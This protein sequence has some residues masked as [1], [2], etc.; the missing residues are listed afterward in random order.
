[1]KNHHL[2]KRL[3]IVKNVSD[4]LQQF[5]NVK[6]VAVTGSCA[7]GCPTEKSDIDLQ[8]AFSEMPYNTEIEK[9]RNRLLDKYGQCKQHKWIGSEM[10]FGLTIEDINISV[11]YGKVDDFKSVAFC[12]QNIG[13]D[14]ESSLSV[15]YDMLPFYDSMNICGYIRDN[16]EYT[17]EKQTEILSNKINELKD[18]FE[19]D[20]LKIL[21]NNIMILKYKYLV[22]ENIVDIIY[23]LNKRPKRMVNDF[24]YMA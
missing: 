19:Y 3:K 23:C 8:V 11:F 2:E 6:M 22:L 16:F 5:N 21:N 13:T 20:S 17:D 1:M 24:I 15:Y 18:L 12:S 9:I 4:E 10:T 14:G 7:I